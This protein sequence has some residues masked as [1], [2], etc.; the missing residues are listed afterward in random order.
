[1]SG[2]KYGTSFLIST[3]YGTYWY[4]YDF[5]L[6]AFQNLNKNILGY[7]YFYLR[8]VWV[9]YLRSEIPY[10]GFFAVYQYIIKRKAI[11]L[12][13]GGGGGAQWNLRGGQMKQCRIK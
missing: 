12:R 10:L 3:A 4:G 13:W 9:P 11:Q 5:R 2:V 1:M 6:F 7:R 8:T